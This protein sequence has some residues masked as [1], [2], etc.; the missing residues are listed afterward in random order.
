MHD[1]FRFFRIF[2]FAE[3]TCFI[4]FLSEQCFSNSR[5]TSEI[6]TLG[7]AGSTV[8]LAAQ[9]SFV[10]FV[11]REEFVLMFQPF[12]RN[13]PPGKAPPSRG[14]SV[15]QKNEKKQIGVPVPHSERWG[16][17]RNVDFG[18]STFREGPTF[19]SSNACRVGASSPIPSWRSL[20]HWP[21]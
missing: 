17:S 6:V 12:S 15:S 20:A 18:E 8:I 7:Q 10:N 16:P 21:R 2:S 11:L 1:W 9:L 3:A 19:R 4:G 5:T 14:R 13:D